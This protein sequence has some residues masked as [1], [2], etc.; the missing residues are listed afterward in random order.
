MYTEGHPETQVK[1]EIGV[2]DP[3]TSKKE[4]EG[5]ICNLIFND[6]RMRKI[7]E[8]TAEI[9]GNLKYCMYNGHGISTTDN[10]KCLCIEVPSIAYF[11]GSDRLPNCIYLINKGKSK[12]SIPEM[13]EISKAMT[14]AVQEIIYEDK[15]KIESRVN[16]SYDTGDSRLMKY[17]ILEVQQQ[18]ENGL[19]RHIGY[20]NV[21]FAK[22]QDAAN[23]YIRYNQGMREMR[24]WISDWNPVTK[25][26]FRVRKWNQEALTIPAYNLEHSPKKTTIRGGIECVNFNLQ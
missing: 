18:G 4:L 20:M 21:M 5:K 22:K 19:Y 7:L 1:I 26:R 25:Q 24:D 3:K 23:Y 11:T 13:I 6:P 12:F 15:A 10:E 9:V 14:L 2:Y 16:V 8:R 17:Y